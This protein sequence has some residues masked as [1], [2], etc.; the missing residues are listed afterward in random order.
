MA[1]NN[2]D[3]KPLNAHEEE[4][5]HVVMCVQ[6]LAH[7]ISILDVIKKIEGRLD[8]IHE[9]AY[10]MAIIQ[11]A[12]PFTSA[13]GTVKYRYKQD[14]GIVERKHKW[15]HSH[16][17]SLRDQV[18]AHSDLTPRQ[19][20]IFLNMANSDVAAN[21]SMRAEPNLPDVNKV[22]ELALQV[23]DA[24]KAK[25]LSLSNRLLEHNAIK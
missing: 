9:A 17:I 11:Y 21:V 19:A 23:F 12:R 15:M 5:F 22:Y 24:L 14:S 16:L 4:Y 1:V 6:D 2:P 8:K 18:L 13:F 20:T 7:C 10:K 3:Y 25:K